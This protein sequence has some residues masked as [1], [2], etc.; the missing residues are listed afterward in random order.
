M[1]AGYSDKANQGVKEVTVGDVIN[2][3]GL[4]FDQK[5]TPEAQDN[6]F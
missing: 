5:D 1:V 6:L 3:P 4:M 2:H